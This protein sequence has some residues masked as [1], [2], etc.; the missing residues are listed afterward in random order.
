[1]LSSVPGSPLAGLTLDEAGNLYG[2]TS[3]GG[4]HGHGSVFKLTSSNGTWTLTS[5][6]DFSDGADGGYPQSNLILDAAGNI[7]ST[8][9]AGGTGCGNG[10]GVVFEITP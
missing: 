3:N 2:T 7:Y 9:S 5:L 8:A 1:M 6:Y 4:L 10:C